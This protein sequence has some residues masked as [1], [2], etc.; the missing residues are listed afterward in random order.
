MPFTPAHV[1]AVLPLVRRRRPGWVVPAAWV[2][3][4]M[5]P[6]L[7]YFTPAGWVR[8]LSHSLKGL[9][10]LDPALGVGLLLAWWLLLAPAVRDL[11][12]RSLRS[13]V[14]PSAL[15]GP[16]RWPWVLVGLFGGSLTHVAWDAFTHHDGWVVRRVPALDEPVLGGHPAYS[17]LQDLS[18]VVGMAALALWAVL[19]LRSAAPVHD[20]V[21]VLSRRERALA[22]LAVAVVPVVLC[23]AL[24]AL[25]VPSHAYFVNALFLGFTRG[26]GISVAAVVLAAAGWQLLRRRRTATEPVRV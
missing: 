25:E 23:A 22:V 11:L 16:G 20:P 14:Q 10:T 19:A 18:G 24:T 26:V 1:A 8:P 15:P 12:P 4:S 17:V 2:V 13:R 7:V 5:S 21:A 6:D 3:G 9:L